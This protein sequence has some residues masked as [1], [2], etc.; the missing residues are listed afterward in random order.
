MKRL[1]GG[2]AAAAALALAALPSGAGQHFGL[3]GGDVLTF[4]GSAAMAAVQGP[5]VAR[6][7]VTGYF[8]MTLD[9]DKQDGDPS[10]ATLSGCIQVQMPT[11][12]DFGCV[13]QLRVPM[14]MPDPTMS[15][16]SVSVSVPSTIYRKPIHVELKFQAD[17]GTPTPEL[18]VA[19]EP[20]N[21]PDFRAVFTGGLSRRGFVSGTVY[22]EGL[23]SGD[24]IDPA[25]GGKL[26]RGAV[27]TACNY[28]GAV[29]P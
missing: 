29:C 8:A 14:T 5:V 7:Y 17:A 6:S 28:Q 23:G 22:S 26:L 9:I 19:V 1:F 25:T 2:I 18:S 13:R 20:P 24:D 10:I 15:R 11:G 21:Y 12:S 4:G 27:L 3:Q 16:A